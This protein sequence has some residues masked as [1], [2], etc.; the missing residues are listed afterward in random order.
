[1]QSRR[2]RRNC[3]AAGTASEDLPVKNARYENGRTVARDAFDEPV[4]GI[5]GEERLRLDRGRR[6]KGQKADQRKAPAMSFCSFEWIADDPAR[7]SPRSNARSA[8][9]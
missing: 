3:P 6:S 1:M 9:R 8:P 5:D 2:K 4:F 7:Y